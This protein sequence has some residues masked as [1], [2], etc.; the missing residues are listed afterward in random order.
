MPESELLTELQSID[1]AI[2][3]IITA[4]KREIRYSLQAQEHVKKRLRVY[5]QSEHFNQPHYSTYD[6]RGEI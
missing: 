5:V 4:Q 2:S 6:S 3:K 1:D